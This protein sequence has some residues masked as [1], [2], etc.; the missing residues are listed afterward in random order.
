MDCNVEIETV[1]AAVAASECSLVRLCGKSYAPLGLWLFR[2][3]F[4]AYSESYRVEICTY[5]GLREGD[6]K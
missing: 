3:Y 2:N 4:H 5:A 6:P 1:L